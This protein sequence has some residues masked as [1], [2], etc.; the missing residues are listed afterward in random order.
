MTHRL[1]KRWHL[2]DPRRRTGA[3]LGTLPHY[4]PELVVRAIVWVIRSPEYTRPG[5]S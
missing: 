1:T 5:E 4:L 2:I 3:S